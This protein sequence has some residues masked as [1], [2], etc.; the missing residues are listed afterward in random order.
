MVIW[1]YYRLPDQGEPVHEAFLLQKA[2]ILME[3]FNHPDICWGN[4]TMGCKLSRRLLRCMEDNFQAQ[5]LDRP[6]SSRVS[7][8]LVFINADE[9]IKEVKVA[10]TLGWSDHALAE[11]VIRRNRGLTKSR[12]GIL[13]FR[14]VNFCSRSC[15]KRSPVK[16]LL[17]G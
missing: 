12:V 4:N 11:P 6:T 15:W 9:L 5:V 13:N 1:A 8:D 3:D 10:G 16:L 17:G 14:R 7:L 2:L